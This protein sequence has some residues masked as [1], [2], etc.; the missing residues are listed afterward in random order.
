ME[1]TCL[2]RRCRPFVPYLPYSPGHP[3]VRRRRCAPGHRAGLY[4]RFVP[5]LPAVRA[6]LARRLVRAVQAVL[7]LPVPVP[8]VPVPLALA[9]FGN[10]RIATSPRLNRYHPYQYTGL[11]SL[12]SPLRFC[13]TLN[14]ASAVHG[15]H[16]GYCLRRATK[17]CPY[18]T[19]R[20]QRT[21]SPQ[22]PLGVKENRPKCIPRQCPF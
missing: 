6:A 14:A 2:D 21:G 11:F 10:R 3:A 13:R 17:R 16:W 8:P 20:S 22:A 9:L 19:A 5:A 1:R 15:S 12:N 18:C 7:A 4:P